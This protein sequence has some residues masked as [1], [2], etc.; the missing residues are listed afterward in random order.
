MPI[1]ITEFRILGVKCKAGNASFSQQQIR[2]HSF[3]FGKDFSTAKY[4]GV[5]LHFPQEAFLSRSKPN[6]IHFVLYCRAQS[7]PI[8]RRAVKG[9]FVYLCSLRHVRVHARRHAQIASMLGGMV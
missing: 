9:F 3:L 5:I 6:I 1:A 8:N 4:C 7:I 2:N